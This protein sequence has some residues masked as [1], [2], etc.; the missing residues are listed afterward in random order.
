MSV[1]SI[2]EHQQKKKTNDDNWPWKYSLCISECEWDNTKHLIV[3]E[4]IRFQTAENK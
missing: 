3:A 4:A 1:F 2:L